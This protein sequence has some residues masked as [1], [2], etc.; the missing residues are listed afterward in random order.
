[1]LYFILFILLMSQL[2]LFYLYKDKIK[3]YSGIKRG[4]IVLDPIP[5]SLKVEDVEGIE[6]LICDVI[7]SAKEEGWKCDFQYGIWTRDGYHMVISSPDG[8]VSID[9]IIRMGYSESPRILRFNITSG[10]KYLNVGG[11][12]YYNEIMLFLWDFILEKHINENSN[13]YK[14]I[15][16]KI[17]HITKNLRSLRRSRLLDELLEK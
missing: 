17:E 6:D 12:K 10:D 3:K 7:S 8:L 9:S 11:G 4:S 1:M 13:E 2:F 15:K 5:M 16:D 14:V